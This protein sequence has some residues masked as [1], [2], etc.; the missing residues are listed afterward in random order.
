[1][2]DVK[3]AAHPAGGRRNLAG[4]SDLPSEGSFST[5]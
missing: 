1:M 5:A 4:N 2:R 3:I